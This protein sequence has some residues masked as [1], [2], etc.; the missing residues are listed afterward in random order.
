MVIRFLHSCLLTALCLSLPFHLMADEGFVELDEAVH[1]SLNEAKTPGQWAALMP[2]AEAHSYIA[3]DGTQLPLFLFPAAS[4][5]DSRPGA[6]VLFAGGAFRSGNP[7]GMTAPVEG[8]PVLGPDK[9]Y[10]WSWYTEERFGID[11]RKVSP[12]HHL[13][14]NLPPACLMM[15][16][17]EKPA[18]RRGFFLAVERATELGALWDAHL[19]A[20][21]PHGAMMGS[22][23]WQPEVY[24]ANIEILT[25]F[26]RRHGF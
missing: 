7:T 19:H 25:R 21:M 9:P 1:Q 10:R 8:D 15:G 14:E 24:R 18:Q 17:K 6:V 3:A 5:D 13:H 26:L 2:E 23:R 4:E 20:A 12:Y 16:G 11:P 22:A